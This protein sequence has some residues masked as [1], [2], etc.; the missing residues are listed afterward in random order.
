M[1]KKPRRPRNPLALV[2]L[3]QLL[4]RPMHPYEMAAQMR[5]RG[6][7]EV[8]RL[9]YGALYSVVESLEGAELIAPVET[10]RDGRRPERTLYALTEAGRELFASWLREILG[11]PAQEFPIFAA[12]LAFIS[13]CPP[14]EGVRL[15]RERAATL[16][17]AIGEAEA[18]LDVWRPTVPR[19]FLIESEYAQTMRR[20]E[21]EWVR[22]LADEIEGGT[23]EGVAEW[24]RLHGPGG[25]APLAPKRGGREE[26]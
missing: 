3:A 18:T 2:V 16:E 19:L 21:L 6:H 25:A 12:G 14:Q 8:I 1:T 11:E 5:H 22:R 9:N 24:R 23:L 13:G 20:A 10:Q 17:R 15:L 4:E 26:P 7:H